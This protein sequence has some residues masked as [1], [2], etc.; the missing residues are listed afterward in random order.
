M[1]K[2]LRKLAYNL[3]KPR[4]IVVTKG[5]CSCVCPLGI[6]RTEETRF[7]KIRF[8]TA[9]TQ[10]ATVLCLNVSQKLSICRQ[11]LRVSFDASGPHTRVTLS[12]NVT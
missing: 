12:Q 7:I 11:F 4:Q 6:T 10:K 8:L 3:A 5:I 1:S 2:I 9:L